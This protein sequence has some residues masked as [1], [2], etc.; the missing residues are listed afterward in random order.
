MMEALLERVRTGQALVGDGA[1]GTQLMARGLKPGECPE[2]INLERPHVLAEIAR[3]YVTAGAELVTT[4]TFGGSPAK[5]EPYGL[6]ARTGEVNRAAVEA[7]REVVAGRAYV[8]AS[9][10]PSGRLLKPYGD[11]EPEE[12]AAGFA[13]Q[14]R[15]LAGAGADAICVETMTDLREATL[16]VEAARSEASG[17]PIVATMTFDPTPRG[18]FTIMGVTVEQAANGLADAG[19]HMVGS[20]CGNGIERMVEIAEAFSKA[21]TLPIAIQSNAGLP[22][23]RGGEIVY[24]ETP[25]FM[26]EHA[27][28]LLDL[29]VSLIGGCCGTGPEH[30]RALRAMVDAAGKAR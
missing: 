23:N 8:L 17:L 26:A 19:A 30:I 3:L 25:E 10:G 6:D 24:P 21:T 29:G 11:T 27:R 18:Y 12:L 16:A 1:W 5:L 28:R 15:A 2:A 7:V 20:N 13:R 22:V 14:V 9:V 4:N